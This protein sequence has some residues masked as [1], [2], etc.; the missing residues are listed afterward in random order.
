MGQEIESTNYTH[1]TNGLWEREEHHWEGVR[2][3]E[4]VSPQIT[5]I[6]QIGLWE[7]GELHWGGCARGGDASIRRIAQT[8]C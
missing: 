5:Q 6:S 2:G 4:R 7:P 1:Y 3:R 8:G